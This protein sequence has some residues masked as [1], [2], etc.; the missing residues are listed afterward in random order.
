LLK[1]HKLK[2]SLWLTA[3]LPPEARE[4]LRTLLPEPRREV[5]EFRVPPRL[6]YTVGRVPWRD[7]PGALAHWVSRQEGAGI[8]FVFS[9][10]STLRVTRLL[11]A[12]G[13]A[14][15]PYHAGMSQ[16]ERRAL[17]GQVRSQRVRAVVATNAFGMGMDF[18]HLRWVVLWQ[19][20]PSLLSL[21]QAV[22][23]V[24]RA[25]A[26]GEALVLWDEEDFRSLEWMTQ[27]EPRKIAALRRVAEYLRSPGPPRERLE[28]YFSGK[29]IAMNAG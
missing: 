28:E 7:R 19:A 21:A 17:E 2:R 13:V 12:A 6:G 15:V 27:G 10:S 8:V 1:E 14:A 23:R 25:G 3:T 26:S 5:G 11:Q 29:W 16:E 18:P 24:G 22:G 20:P 9:R 4:D